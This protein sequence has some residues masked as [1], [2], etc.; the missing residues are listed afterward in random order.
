MPAGPPER[1]ISPAAFYCPV[2]AV[3][4][5]EGG[6]IVPLRGLFAEKKIIAAKKN[7]LEVEDE[8]K[9]DFL[10]CRTSLCVMVLW[11]CEPG[12]RFFELLHRSF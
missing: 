3:A 7:T 11:S 4:R 2:R 6:D 1:F 8:T 10:D 9:G 5:Q 12:V